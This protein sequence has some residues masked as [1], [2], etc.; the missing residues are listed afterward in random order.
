[1]NFLSLDEQDIK[2][3]ISD[4]NEKIFELESILYWNFTPRRAMLEESSVA[5]VVFGI[6]SLFSL[7]GTSSE[8]HYLIL[9]YLCLSFLFWLVYWLGLQDL[10][11]KLT[12]MNL[13]VQVLDILR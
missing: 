3:E 9:S 13:L 8:S 4:K 10:N 12:I 1:M 2:N 11:Q 6:P 7:S 5:F